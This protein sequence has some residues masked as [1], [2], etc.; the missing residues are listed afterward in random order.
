MTNQEDVI[1]AVIGVVDPEPEMS[2][3]LLA[4]RIDSL[5][6]ESWSMELLI[7]QVC[8]QLTQVHEAVNGLKTQIESLQQAIAYKAYEDGEDH[9]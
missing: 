3:D 5:T 9:L 4:E 7:T 8:T 6:A 1:E 2:L